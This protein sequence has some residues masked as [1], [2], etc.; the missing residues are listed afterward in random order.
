MERRFWRLEVPIGHPLE[1][2]A[3]LRFREVAQLKKHLSG[4]DSQIERWSAERRYLEYL[5]EINGGIFESRSEDVNHMIACLVD[6]IEAAEIERMETIKRAAQA[7]RHFAEV[8]TR[9]LDFVYEV[10]WLDWL[11]AIPSEPQNIPLPTLLSQLSTL[12]CLNNHKT[13]LFIRLAL[14]LGYDEELGGRVKDTD[15]CL[16]AHG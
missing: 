3:V 7:F 11:L 14:G 4:L 2:H 12:V 6:P 8:E 5:D 10:L 9:L 1:G 16:M 13:D 15:V